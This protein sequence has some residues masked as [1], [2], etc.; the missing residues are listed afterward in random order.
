M[1]D[2]STC[3]ADCIRSPK[4][5]EAPPTMKIHDLNG[6]HVGQ[7]LTVTSPSMEY[8]GVL[9]SVHHEGDIISE[10]SLA[11]PT[12]HSV[13][14]RHSQLT[15]ASGDVFNFYDDTLVT[16]QPGTFDRRESTRG[17]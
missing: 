11:G 4:N 15:F 3:K 16:V 2:H 5:Y 13:G 12:S 1:I 7:E 8:R 10:T 9:A 17:D 14:R 6:T